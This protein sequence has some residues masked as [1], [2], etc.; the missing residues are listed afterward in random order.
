MAELCKHRMEEVE[1]SIRFFEYN[2]Q[3]EGKAINMDDRDKLIDMQV[4]SASVGLGSVIQ[5]KVAGALAKE[6]MEVEQEEMTIEWRG[7]SVTVSS[8]KLRDIILKSQQLKAEI[9][10]EVDADRRLMLFDRLFVC[11][12]DARDVIK[13]D[14]KEMESRGIGGS[15]LEEKKVT[16]TF[17]DSYL[18]EETLLSTV[19]RNELLVHS[20]RAKLPRGSGVDETFSMP[21]TVSKKARPSTL[22]EVVR[23]CEILNQ[24][25]SQLDDLPSIH[26]D[27]VKAKEAA[28]K[29]FLYKAL[30]CALMA[31]AFA[32]EESPSWNKAMEL[33]D[34]A[35]D[36]LMEAG[37]AGREGGAMPSSC[38]DLMADV[39]K[40][41]DAQQSVFKAKAFLQVMGAQQRVE[42]KEGAEKKQGRGAES[43]TSNVFDYDEGKKSKRVTEFPPPLSTVAVKPVV[44][45]LAY[46]LF[47]YRDLEH[48]KPKKGGIFGFFRK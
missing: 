6:R 45:D 37:E 34:R 27:E 43:V 9:E 28:V 41:V 46:N 31:D 35:S 2:V 18:H 40:K 48:R 39:E 32:T 30:R 1:S 23:M 29:G 25:I 26:E 5:G 19:H 7:K 36:Y 20:M 12:N 14:L 3:R 38:A 13:E 11:F 33:N 42:E 16:S 44:F 24:A 17:I 8:I 10:K 15:R 22:G 4:A 47:Q 21:I